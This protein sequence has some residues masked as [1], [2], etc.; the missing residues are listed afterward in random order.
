MLHAKS[1]NGGLGVWYKHAVEG[2]RFCDTSENSK[3]FARSTLERI[4]M[5]VDPEQQ[6]DGQTWMA[7]ELISPLQKVAVEYEAFLENTGNALKFFHVNT[8]GKTTYG[9]ASH[10]TVGVADPI[11]LGLPESAPGGEERAGSPAMLAM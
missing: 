8:P 5:F 3:S 7:M 1:S 10:S 4:K 2:G 9:G 6:T 11:N